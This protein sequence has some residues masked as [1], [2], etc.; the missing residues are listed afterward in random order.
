MIM[1]IPLHT[2]AMMLARLDAWQRLTRCALLAL[3]AMLGVLCALAHA[4]DPVPGSLDTTPFPGFASGNGKIANITV[5]AHGDY[6]RAVAVQPDGKIV[7][8]GNCQSGTKTLFCIARLNADGSA[9]T[10]FVGPNNSASGSFLLAI[11]STSDIAYT[12]LLQPDGKIVL[13]GSC[14][15]G[16]NYDFCVARL[17]PNGSLDASFV[18]PGNS[19]N[20]KF[21]LPVASGNDTVLASALQPDG[22]IILAGYCDIATDTYFCTLRLNVNGTLDSSFV[23]PGAAG[24]S[25]LLPHIGAGTDVARAVALQADGR[26]VLAGVCL[27]GGVK[28]NFC[29]ARLH[30]DGTVD[31]NFVGPG[32][33]GNGKFF[34]PVASDADE[35]N[36]VAVQPD[37]KIVLAGRCLNGSDDDFCVARLNANGTLDVT[38]DGSSGTANGSVLFPVGQGADVIVAMAL[39]PDGKIVLAGYCSNGSNLDFCVAR[40]NGDGSR[41]ST[42]DGPSVAGNGKFLLPIG[43]GV[44]N[45]TGMALQADGK[46]VIA[47]YC[48]NGGNI[49][50]CV[51]RLNGG[52]FGAQNCSLDMDGDGKVLATVDGLIATRVMLGFTGNAVINGITFA[53]HATRQTWG[54]IRHYLVSQCGMAI[55]P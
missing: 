29:A 36:A 24:T 41:D 23:G 27:I 52:P 19:G 55:A 28:F 20:G 47:G 3:F 4:A 15:N 37:G 6:A 40:L 8:A 7:L 43:T 53:P 35:A 21:L 16:S 38:F 26:I 39:Q 9:D 25:S 12:V 1:K 22:K 50:F 51:A 44:D 32:G 2:N 18:G 17:N 33:V 54:Q 34:V 10:S 42:F 13:A 30:A 14:S 45:T 11:G 49:D 46:I 5:G 48:D 31:A